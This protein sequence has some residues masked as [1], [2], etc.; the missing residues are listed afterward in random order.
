RLFSS[1]VSGPL[2]IHLYGLGFAVNRAVIQ[3][4]VEMRYAVA[5]FFTPIDD[6]YAEIYSMLSMEKTFG[7]LLTYVLLR[8]ASRESRITI[9]QD[10][11]IW[12]NK[13]YRPQP[14]LSDGDG[15]IM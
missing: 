2:D 14:K 1:E 5:V 6:D 3:T 12:E 13:L 7:S 11:P 8:K 4:K 15:P 10:I 9:D